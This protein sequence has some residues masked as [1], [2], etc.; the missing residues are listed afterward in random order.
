LKIFCRFLLNIVILGTDPFTILKLDGGCGEEAAERYRRYVEEAVRQG[1][2]VT[3]IEI[4]GVVEAVKGEK[5]EEFRDRHGDW[6]RDLVFYLGRKDWALKLRDLG[7]AA[8]GVDDIAVSMAARRIATRA[9]SAPA[10]SSALKQC[11]QKL[12]MLN[13]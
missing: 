11:R 13:V 1:L 7:A 6:G 4:I 2:P 9:T 12:E 8:G 3:V 10:I 5:W